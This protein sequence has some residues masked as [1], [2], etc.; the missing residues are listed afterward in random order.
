MMRTEE[1]WVMDDD[2]EAVAA[3]L[4]LGVG[5]QAARVLT[6]LLL[7]AEDDRIE[8]PRARQLAIRLGTG[9]SRQG[10]IDALST[11]SGAELVT[12]ST[13]DS[14]WGRPPKAW[15]TEY[16][17]ERAVRDA[18]ARRAS[19]LLERA[20]IDPDREGRERRQIRLGLNWQPNGLHLPFYAAREAYDE[21]GVDVEFVHYRGSERALA[22]VADGD[23]DLGVVGS[24][25]LTDARQQGE[26]V[27]P[28]AVLYQRAMTVLYTTR[29]AFG[30]SLTRSDQLRGRR[31]GMSPSTETR[32]L[33]ELFLSQ[34]GVAD[35][36]EIL[37]TT[38]EESAAL[39]AGDADVVT[40]SF[41]DPWKLQDEHTV[42]VLTISEQFPIYG[43]ALVVA[44]ETTGAD[45]ETL[46]QF[47]TGTLLGWRAARADPTPAARHIATEAGDS[48][49]AIE[50]TFRH[51]IE[52]FADSKA[53]RTEGWGAHHEEEW[54]RIRT[55]LVRTRQLENA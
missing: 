8:D 13:L 9:L 27:T 42:D 19:T 51:A 26:P 44:P 7:R 45:A 25:T 15:S 48:R 43:P 24:V 41:S 33:A 46:E 1:F 14:E 38:G 47:L 32:L 54:G 21:L 37:E 16:T 4:E 55:A 3:D 30:E 35:D 36:V 2:D 40:G 10:V 17:V 18:Y 29:E 34:A 31:I 12:E 49:E 5:T 39:R 6:Y 11:L 23:V 28:L 22:A 53:S 50:R 20:G 52:S